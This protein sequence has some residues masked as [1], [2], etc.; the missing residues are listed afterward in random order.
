ME[1][2][3]IYHRFALF[4]S[5]ANFI[6]LGAQKSLQG[7][8]VIRRSFT[9]YAPDTPGGKGGDNIGRIKHLNGQA[10]ITGDRR[11]DPRGFAHH[12]A[13]GHH[14]NRGKGCR[15][16]TSQPAREQ[17]ALDFVRYH[18]LEESYVVASLSDAVMRHCSIAAH[19]IVDQIVAAKDPV[20]KFLCRS[21]IPR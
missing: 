3:N 15:I 5:R 4:S 6:V 11:C 2:F 18:R 21:E 13:L 12:H 9:A 1:A 19:H 14:T 16:G 17:Q 7:Q 20:R 8:S 10:S